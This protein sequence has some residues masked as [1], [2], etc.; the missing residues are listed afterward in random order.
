MRVCFRERIKVKDRIT[1][2]ISKNTVKSTVQEE[3]EG[4]EGEGFPYSSQESG[5]FTQLFS[6]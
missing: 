1:Q 2:K 3:Q 5:K 6:T 4:R